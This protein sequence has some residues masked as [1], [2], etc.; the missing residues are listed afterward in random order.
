MAKQIGEQADKIPSWSWV[1]AAV[2][3][4]LVAGSAGFMLFRA[5]AG[6][7]SPPDLVIETEAVVPNGS[8]Y[9]VPI[10]VA[11]RG[12]SAAAGLTVE[13]VLMEG[14]VTVETSAITMD[15][16]PSSSQRKARLFFSRDPRKFDLQVRAKGY[17]QP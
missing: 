14:T 10:R 15:Y 8:S 6:D 2:G 5:L 3:L 12:G 9:L 17:E 16:V 4:A 11:N 1:A 7:P 13:G